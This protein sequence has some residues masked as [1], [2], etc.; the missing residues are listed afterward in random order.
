MDNEKLLQLAREFG[1]TVDE[2]IA[3][4]EATIALVSA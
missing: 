3:E 1:V 4:L 2:I